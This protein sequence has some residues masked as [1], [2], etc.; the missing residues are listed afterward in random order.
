MKV[1]G[2][3]DSQNGGAGT[4]TVASNGQVQVDTETK[5]YNNVSSIIIDKG[6]YSTAT[7]DAVIGTTPTIK[8]TD[9]ISTADTITL[10]NTN[11]KFEP[12]LRRRHRR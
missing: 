3:N 8:I 4:L 11:L 9:P 5:F 7:L 1:G 6:T 2:F 12:Q 10:N